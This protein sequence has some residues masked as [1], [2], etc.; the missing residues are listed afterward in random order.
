MGKHSG[1]HAFREK[2]RELGYELGANALEDAFARFKDLADHKKDVFDEDIIG[3]G[4]RR[5]RCA[6]NDRI[7]FVSLQV[8]AGSNGPQLADLELEIDGEVRDVQARG[9]GPVDATFNAIKKLFPHDGAR[10]CSTR[11]TP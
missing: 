7:K 1:R 2:L 8:V 5:D 4:R 6:S 11:C 10:S 3:A 9:N